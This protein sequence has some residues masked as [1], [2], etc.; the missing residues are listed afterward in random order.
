MRA[1]V[2]TFVCNYQSNLFFK[3]YM[4]P[5]QLSVLLL[6]MFICIV[7]TGFVT[8]HIITIFFISCAIQIVIVRLSI[9]DIAYMW[10]YCSNLD[11]YHGDFHFCHSFIIIV[12]VIASLSLNNYHYI[13]VILS[14]RLRCLHCVV[15]IVLLALRH[16]YCHYLIVIAS[17]SSRHYHCVVVILLL[18]LH[19]S[20]CHRVITYHC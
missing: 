15:V 7:I 8:K 6:S 5:L 10:S 11:M 9:V 13:V 1:K 14:L 3:S 16:R 2:I 4:W 17:L 20:H 18:S 19:H 12:I